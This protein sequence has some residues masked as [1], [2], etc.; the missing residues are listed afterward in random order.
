MS[1][2]NSNA[3]YVNVVFTHLT[4]NNEYISHEMYQMALG[5]LM[6]DIF[7]FGSYQPTIIAK[8]VET[9][10][11]EMEA[12]TA[13][14]TY[15]F[16]YDQVYGDLCSYL[17]DTIYNPLNAEALAS[18][19]NLYGT[20]EIYTVQHSLCYASIILLVTPQPIKKFTPH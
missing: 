10:M 5:I 12:N 19:V 1:T 18:L 4:P 6:C 14:L 2:T 3:M 9:T 17:E 16:A 13:S 20:G 15:S 11:S 8:A 7:L